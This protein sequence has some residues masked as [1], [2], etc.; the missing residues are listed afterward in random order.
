MASLS[1]VSYRDAQSQA[2]S[3]ETVCDDDPTQ[4]VIE[5][6]C[7]FVEAFFAIPDED[8]EANL[9]RQSPWLLRLELDRAKILDKKSR[10]H[11]SRRC[12]K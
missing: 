12:L 6:D 11:S 2:T 7:D 8:I 1:S 10:C 4:A 5:D 3:T 9:S